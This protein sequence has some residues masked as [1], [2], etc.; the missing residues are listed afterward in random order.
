MRK[1]DDVHPGRPDGRVPF[2]MPRITLP[3]LAP[4]G[5][6]KG[7]IEGLYRDFGAFFLEIDVEN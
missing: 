7:N 1:P 3:F 2:G 4:K 5:D 6:R